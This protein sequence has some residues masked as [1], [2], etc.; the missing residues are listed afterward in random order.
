MYSNVLQTAK[1]W[2]LEL[3]WMVASRE[4]RDGRGGVPK[5][6]W[7]AARTEGKAPSKKDFTNRQF[8]CH[9]DDPQEEAGGLHGPSPGGRTG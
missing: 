3:V 2:Q 1:V 4:T 6:L 8:R 5:Q 9:N 7:L